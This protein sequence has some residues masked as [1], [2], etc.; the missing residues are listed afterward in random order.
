MILRSK[1]QKGIFEST[2]DLGVCKFVSVSAKTVTGERP[3]ENR[4]GVRHFHD[5]H[6][7]VGHWLV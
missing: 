5:K 2:W 7:S 4:K 6:S 1:I 3:E